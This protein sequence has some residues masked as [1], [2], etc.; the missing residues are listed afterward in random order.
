[1]VD[2]EL[3]E[4]QGFFDAPGAPFLFLFF[5]GL[6]CRGGQ[7]ENMGGL[8]DIGGA[9]LHAG[10]GHFAVEAAGEHDQGDI[11]MMLLKVGESLQGIESG[12]EIIGDDDIGF[13]RQRLGEAL[14]GTDTYPFP[15]QTGV[16]ELTRDD[17]GLLGLFLDDN[18]PESALHC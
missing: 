18:K 16:L 9:G 4:A 6:A 10:H 17:L 13:A 1:V 2:G 8:D 11:E 15:E 12:E 3:G 14:G 7:T 5:D